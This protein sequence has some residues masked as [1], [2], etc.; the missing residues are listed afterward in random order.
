MYYA[1]AAFFIFCTFNVTFTNLTIF[2]HFLKMSDEV[3]CSQILR[4]SCSASAIKVILC[5]ETGESKAAHLRCLCCSQAADVELGAETGA[6]WA[7]AAVKTG[8]SPFAPLAASSLAPNHHLARGERWFGTLRRW[9]IQLDRLFGTYP[10]FLA[11]H[12]ACNSL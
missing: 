12:G 6:M 7:T 3:Q 9:R 11:A 1:A 2:I 10:F 4:F 5:L 8:F